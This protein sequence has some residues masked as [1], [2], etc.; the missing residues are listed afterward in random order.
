[1]SVESTR[2]TMMRYFSADHSDTSMLA[3]DVVFTIMSTGQEHRGREGVMGMLHF[4]YHIAFDA[5][6]NTRVTLFG[7]A[8]AMIEA[9][10]IGKHIGEF[11]GIPATG[12]EVNVPLCVVYD[13]ENDLIARGRVYFEVPA[14]RAQLGL[15]R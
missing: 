5:T 8:N 10:F 12:K 11:A 7:E 3:E 15:P 1:M 9:D 13:L 2:A 4:F 14:L 6:A